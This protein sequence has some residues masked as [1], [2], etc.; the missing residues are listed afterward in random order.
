RAAQHDGSRDT[1]IEQAGHV[2]IEQ[3]SVDRRQSKR[4]AEIVDDSQFVVDIAAADPGRQ[5]RGTIAAGVAVTIE[6]DAG[7]NAA[8][9]KT[10]DH[11]HD[12]ADLELPGQ[13]RRR[14][15]RD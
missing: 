12:S 2:E 14:L 15:D 10:A 3:R 9:R 13:D 4:G 11:L 7:L 8:D 1:E 5:T 6:V